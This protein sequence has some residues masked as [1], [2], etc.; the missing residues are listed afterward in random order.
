MNNMNPREEINEEIDQLLRD[1]DN[2]RDNAEY[3]EPG[4]Y[5]EQQREAQQIKR[6]LQDLVHELEDMSEEQAP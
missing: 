5:Y 4:I 2:L 1:L 6:R 3:G